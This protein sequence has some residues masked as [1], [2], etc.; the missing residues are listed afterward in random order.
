MLESDIRHA[1]PILLCQQKKK[2]LCNIDTKS[3]DMNIDGP[4]QSLMLAGLSPLQVGLLLSQQNLGDSVE[5]MFREKQI[6]GAVQFVV[7][8]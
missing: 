5:T 6:S 8:H 7:S 1:N 4:K 3:V 2:L